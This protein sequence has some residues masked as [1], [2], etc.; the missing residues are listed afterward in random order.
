[1]TVSGLPGQINYELVESLEL[2][3]V[4]E[5][6]RDALPLATFRNVRE[7]MPTPVICHAPSADRCRG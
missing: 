6:A 4:L 3:A 7:P 1:M 2:L 5:D